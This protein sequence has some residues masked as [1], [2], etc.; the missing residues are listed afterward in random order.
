MP[1]RESR[2]SVI[3]LFSNIIFTLAYGEEMIAVRGDGGNYMPVL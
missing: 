3:D 2:L 1:K